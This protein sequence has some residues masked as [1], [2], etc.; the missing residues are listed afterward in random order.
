M[1]KLLILTFAALLVAA[2]SLP[3]AAVE[4]E[5]GG[6]WRTR[7]F[8]NRDFSGSS[9]GANDES[10]DFS[11][12]DTRTR[13]Y[14]FA[15]LNDNLKFV[16]KFEF[17]ADWG[18]D[19]TEYGD[20]GADGIAVQ[21]KNS[22]ADATFGMT[23]AKIGAQGATLARGFLFS[24][25]FSGI[26]LNFDLDTLQ[27]PL[28]WIRMDEGGVGKDA[29]DGDADMVAVAPTFGFGGV[30]INPLLAWL[31]TQDFSQTDVL[32][33]SP[34]GVIPEPDAVTP[35]TYEKV[36]LYYVGVNADATFGPANVWFTGIYNGG[37]AKASTAANEDLDIA[38]FL[39]ALGGGAN[40]GIFEAHGQVFYATGDDESDS[41]VKDFVGPPGQSYYWSEIM[42]YG[43]FDDQVSNGSPADKISDI[44]AV[45]LGGS[46]T[47]M[48]KLTLGLDI[49]YAQRAEKQDAPYDSDDEK[50]LG[51][52][53]DFSVKYALLEDLTLEA[54]AAYL[55]ADDG[56]D[57]TADN[58][59]TVNP[60]ELGAQ[61]S[62]SF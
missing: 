27:I 11:M 59:D 62:L 51:T 16:N 28:Y 12:V 45:G 8:M 7:F 44:M 60:F 14:Y 22:Y 30:S 52:E 29:N 48:E 3:A 36:N 21:V 25:D 13:L 38:A 9:D 24:D 50:K 53:V 41:D 31:T 18:D 33:L 40:F 26:I 56:T 47:P 5:F 57:I 55:F 17:N 6:Y 19:G 49:W 42:G 10:M 39:V 4:H 35:E 58:N 34:D 54:V 32:S 15:E 1:K 37:T 2:F 23:N 61:L 20:V 46:V 43:I